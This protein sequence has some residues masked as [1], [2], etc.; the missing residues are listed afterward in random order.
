MV[1]NVTLLFIHLRLQE[2]FNSY[3]IEDGWFGGMNLLFFGDLLQLPP[4]AKGDSN[5]FPFMTITASALGTRNSSLL[6][7]VNLWADLFSYDE[8]TIN[9]RQQSDTAFGDLL[10][11]IRLGNMT[12][13]DIEMLQA[14]QIQFTSKDSTACLH[15]LVEVFEEL[16]LDSVC[17]LPRKA[18]CA[19]LN[20]AI[21]SRLPG[22]QT[23]LKATDKIDSKRNI[24]RADALNYLKKLE[25][26]KT[27]GVEETINVKIGCRV[28]L[29]TNKDTKLGL[30]N[31]A[32]GI[33][34]DIIKEGNSVKQIKSKV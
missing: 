29:R 17:L 6:V 16:P 18:Q 9:V 21:L 23:V 34:L 22:K 13:G 24:N 19:E 27:G 32:I 12:T 25:D 2:I 30:V 31:G 4:V 33:I 1:S 26:D 5:I 10:S 28:M 15:K 3:Q 20:A 7:D 11:R 14:R 8:L